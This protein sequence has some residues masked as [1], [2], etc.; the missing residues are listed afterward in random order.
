MI[1]PEQQAQVDRVR[2]EILEI[3]IAVRF[4]P[5][6]RWDYYTEQILAIPGIEI[7]DENQKF[8]EFL[9]VDGI[10]EMELVNATRKS[11]KDNDWVKVII[12]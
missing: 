12:R 9:T 8:P 11:L 3:L 1:T 4:A 6:P 10:S 2:A 5:S 7:R